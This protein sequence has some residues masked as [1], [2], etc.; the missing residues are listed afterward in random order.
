MKYFM[1]FYIATWIFAMAKLYYPSVRFLKSVD[2]DSVLVRREKLGW[3]VA[4]IGFAI[5]VPLL[6]PISLSDKYSKEFIVA[7]CDRALE[8]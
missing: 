6:L 7:F 4:S 1:A 8:G 3:F 2:S 5:A